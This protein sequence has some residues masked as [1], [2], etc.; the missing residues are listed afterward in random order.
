MDKNAWYLIEWEFDS[1]DNP[2]IKEQ[3]QPLNFLGDNGENIPSKQL[4]PH[5]PATYLGVTSQVNGSQTAQYRE[6]HTK[7]EQCARKL[8]STHMS[9]Y[10]SHVYNNC[11]IIPRITYPLAATSLTSKH[12]QKLHA[13]L[14]PSVIASKGFNRYF[15]NQLIFGIHKYSG[16]G[17]LNLEVEQGIRKIHILHKFIY[18]PKHKTLIRAVVDWH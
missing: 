4:Q 1:N 18:H 10:Y 6:L 9:H 11:S 5:E 15:P 14:Y 16:L 12:F 3:T 7:A 2:Y 17:L 8:S 13:S